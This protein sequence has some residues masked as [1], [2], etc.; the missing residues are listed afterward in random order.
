MCQYADCPDA[1]CHY[2]K[3][4]YAE[5]HDD[6]HHLTA[7]H[8]KRHGTVCRYACCLYGECLSAM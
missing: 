6:E 2:A 5:C 3:Y 4:R 8:A 7:C 1:E